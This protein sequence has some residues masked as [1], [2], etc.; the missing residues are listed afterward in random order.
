MSDVPFCPKVQP[1]HKEQEEGYC[2]PFEEKIIMDIAKVKR[3]LR[4]AGTKGPAK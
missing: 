2:R 1:Q 3:D 4:R